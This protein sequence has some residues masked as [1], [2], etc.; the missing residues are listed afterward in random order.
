MI[1]PID[2]S[3]NAAL[4]SPLTPPPN[5]GVNKT[6]RNFYKSSEK[7]RFA[8]LAAILPKTSAQQQRNMNL[9]QQA[10]TGASAGSGHNQKQVM[11]YQKHKNAGHAAGPH[12]QES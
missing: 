8:P 11:D 6:A 2:L 4:M 5:N 9:L 7:G 1:S 12:S 10:K 3:P